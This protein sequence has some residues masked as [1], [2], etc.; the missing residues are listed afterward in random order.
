MKLKHINFVLTFTAL[1][2]ATVLL[3]F[4]I[5]GIITLLAH[6]NTETSILLLAFLLCCLGYAGLF[7]NLFW[8]KSKKFETYTLLFL[9]T[10]FLG[11]ILF[12]SFT[13]GFNT[14]KWLLI[15]KLHKEWFLFG[16]PFWVTIILIVIKSIHLIE[17]KK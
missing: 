6:F 7:M 4:S 17:L 10:G 3:F 14:W 11:F 2:P 15:F 1:F 16:Y 12:T 13:G 9:I 5:I 8:T